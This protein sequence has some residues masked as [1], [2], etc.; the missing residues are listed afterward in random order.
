MMSPLLLILCAAS[1]CSAL[2]YE[3]VW[4]QLL[5][6]A[7]GSTAVSL[8]VLLATFMGG[9]CLGSIGFPRLRVGERHPLRI[10]AALET[11]IALCG[12]LVLMG[13][14]YLDRI[15]I[16]GAEHGLPGMLLRGLLASICLLPPTILMGASLPAIVRWFE[17][18][19]RGVSW[20]GYLYGAN[21][22]GAVF[23]CLFAGFYLLR[24]YSM[25]TAT[26]VAM[27]IN[28]A[29]A[30]LGFA[31]AAWTPQPVTAKR[32]EPAA[33]FAGHWTIYVSIALS[34]ACALGAEV[35][36][37][38]LLGMMLGATVY[39]FSSSWPC[40]WLGWR[41]AARVARG[42]CEK[43]G[44]GPRSAGARFCSC[45]RLRGRSGRFPIPCPTV[46][47]RCRPAHG[48]PSSWI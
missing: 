30:I 5:Q 6:L 46:R 41:Q 14:P 15:Y 16:A 8:G 47:A 31:L 26:Y 23:G 11:G 4:Y 36:W 18:T 42:C 22:V 45:W 10:Y 27:A 32:R 2:I 39:V 13:M 35:V 1:G 25:V 43:Y 24:V 38:R 29:V 17:S 37:T 28:M 3:I 12:I 20:W 40:S 21:T 34:G 7:I 19:P 44:R 48:A 33:R 9:L